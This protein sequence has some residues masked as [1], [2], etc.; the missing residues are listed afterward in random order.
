M[1]FRRFYLGYTIAL[2]GLNVPVLENIFSF[3]MQL[4]F[5]LTARTVR[6]APLDR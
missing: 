4:C 1:T 2:S 5:G 6:W 3:E